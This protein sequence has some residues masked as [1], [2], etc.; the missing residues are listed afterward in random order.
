MEQLQ[1]S[2]HDVCIKFM[3]ELTCDC[4][5]YSSK[6][7]EMQTP[8]FSVSMDGLGDKQRIKV[9]RIN[10]LLT[11]TIF[12]LPK[13]RSEPTDENQLKT[14]TSPELK[15]NC[16]PKT[17]VPDKKESDLPLFIIEN[18]DSPIQLNSLVKTIKT[19]PNVLHEWFSH[20]KLLRLLKPGDIR[21][22]KI[23]QNHWIRGQPAIVSN[24]SSK[25]NPSLWHPSSFSRDFG[26]I[27][28][29]LINCFSGN[30]V[31]NQLMSAFWDGFED[32]SR[33]LRDSN[34]M[35]M[36][37]KLKDWPHGD[38]FAEVLPTR[39]EDLMNNLPLG[40][41]TRRTG[42]LNLA[43]R[44][45]D[46]FV[47][48][49]LGPKMYNAYGSAHHL[50]KGTTN[51]HLDISDAVNIMIYVGVP[52]EFRTEDYRSK[53]IKALLDADC[54]RRSINN[55]IDTKLPGAI[56]HIY[57]PKDAVKIR[58][59]LNKLKIER[60]EKLV[61]SNDPIHDQNFYLDKKLRLRLLSEY[62]E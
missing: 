41:Y 42:N 44:L 60:G 54:D 10:P 15:T 14:Q 38:D 31:P 47:R 57:D 55:I 23:F 8:K 13:R 27:T 18:R 40:E 7:Y 48:P 3:P 9:I 58:D 61:A 59:L 51:L 32:I 22:Y 19:N 29:D 53:I 34:G 35:T 2:M 4:N 49:D 26:H 16:M 28:N 21:N 62:G 24:V 1:K 36:L 6:G 33:R 39:F 43:S 50:Q 25:L 56:W 30:I 17:N 52:I 37:L 12:P 45:P 5:Y 20:G 11:Q 46:A